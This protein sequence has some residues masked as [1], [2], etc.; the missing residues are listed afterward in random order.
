MK[1]ERTRMVARGLLWGA[2]LAVL[3]I[4]AG[5]RLGAA[6]RVLTSLERE[7]SDLFEQSKESVVTVRS[8]APAPFLEGLQG[9]ASIMSHALPGVE[10]SGVVLNAEGY[11]VTSS[12]IAQWS[13]GEVDVVLSD[14]RKFKGEVIGSDP[15]SGIAVVKV[16]SRSLRPA[17]FGSSDRIRAGSWVIILGNAFGVS[18]SMALGMVNA[19]REDGTIQVS[20]NVSPGSSGSPVLNSAGEVIGILNASLSDPF[21]LR[22]GEGSGEDEFRVLNM[23][24]RGSS[25]LTPINNVLEVA[26]ELIA[27]G[28]VERGWLGVHIQELDED[29]REGLGVESGIIVKRVVES[30]P[31]E[32]AGLEVGDVIME[33]DGNPVEST[34]DL[35]RLVMG[36]APGER[37]TLKIRHDGET[38][39]VRVPI[40]SREEKAVGLFEWPD[41]ASLYGKEWQEQLKDGAERLRD[42]VSKDSASEELRA[43]VKRLKEMVKELA[44]SLKR[45][46]AER[47]R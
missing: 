39:R 19:V 8:G 21:T 36:T 47:Q 46:E 2:V 30:S 43:E 1:K 29:L 38:K 12:Q 17:V 5:V 31:A 42:L 41:L 25:L 16:D 45:L 7:L 14:G 44:E 34:S 15:L 32:E 37:V 10:A 40:T 27:H 9:Q 26:D 20:A 6:D 3:V 18:P 13:G 35:R 24:S 28:R 4:S 23:P 33:Y 22:L 11:V